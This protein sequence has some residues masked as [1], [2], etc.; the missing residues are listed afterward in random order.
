MLEAEVDDAF[1]VDDDEEALDVLVLDAA[2]EVLV[3]DAAL[4]VLVLDAALDVLEVAVDP[5]HVN[6]L[7]PVMHVSIRF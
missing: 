4:D 5:S 3:L 6:G 2:L 1:D 7:G